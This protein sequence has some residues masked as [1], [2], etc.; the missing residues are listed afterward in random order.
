MQKRA[1]FPCHIFLPRL[2]HKENNH[3]GD[4]QDCDKTRHSAQNSQDDDP[5]S[6]WTFILAIVT[7]G[8]QL[9]NFFLIEYFG[10]LEVV[11]Y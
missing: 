10:I 2:Y 11:C 6:R 8:E 4:N 7:P 5:V 9:F 1:L 3:C